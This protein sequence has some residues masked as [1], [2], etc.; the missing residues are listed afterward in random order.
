MKKLI[1]VVIG[2]LTIVTAAAGIVMWKHH[3]CS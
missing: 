3:D 1:I 2:L